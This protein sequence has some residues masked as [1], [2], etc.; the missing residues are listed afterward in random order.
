MPWG[1]L[2]CKAAPLP[3]KS[4]RCQPGHAAWSPRSC[5]RR[6]VLAG[7][8][9][10]N[11]PA[12]PPA[13][14]LSF[15][16]LLPCIPGDVWQQQRLRKASI[17]ITLSYVEAL[18]W[19]LKNKSPLRS[20]QSRVR[21]TA[22]GIRKRLLFLWGPVTAVE[23][24]ASCAHRPR[25]RPSCQE[26]RCPIGRRPC[27]EGSAPGAPEEDAQPRP[28]GP[29]RPLGWSSLE[30]KQCPSVPGF[31]GGP[32]PLRG[33]RG[34]RPDTLVGADQRSQRSNL[35][36]LRG[37]GVCEPGGGRDFVTNQIFFPS[38][39]LRKRRLERVFLYTGDEDK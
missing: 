6:A 14:F 2:A 22:P 33:A 25:C 7:L 27:G 17:F 15:P 28:S 8:G 30:A 10:A 13:G 11:K 4:R 16:L 19:L 34:Q 36:P 35:H 21:L 32:A 12:V 23:A 26:L 5:T 20:S 38:R 37:D 39:V 3:L 29:G 1:L 24:A 18:K 31:G 9:L